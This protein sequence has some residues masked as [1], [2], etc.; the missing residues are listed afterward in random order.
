MTQISNTKRRL[1]S[2]VALA[3]AVA[4]GV[5]IAP[6]LAPADSALAS[7]ASAATPD[8]S[9]ITRGTINKDAWLPACKGEDTRLAYDNRSL[10]MAQTGAVEALP[11]ATYITLAHHFYGLKGKMEVVTLIE[12]EGS[13]SEDP[14][15][16]GNKEFSTILNPLGLDYHHR[17]TS[18]HTSTGSSNDAVSYTHLTLPTILLV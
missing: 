18:W 17:P 11:F 9:L 3:A 12:E 13:E 14:N 1:V 10:V 16:N 8:E 4:S 5:S 6:A 15:Y 2:G 7:T